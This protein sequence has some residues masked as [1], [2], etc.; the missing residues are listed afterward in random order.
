M[1]ECTF[2]L[3]GFSV[4]ISE[5]GYRIAAEKEKSSNFRFIN[6]I[7]GKSMGLHLSNF[8]FIDFKTT[9]IE[10]SKKFL[11]KLELCPIILLFC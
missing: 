4:G 11:I 2:K 3:W 1:Y 5:V 10:S 6:L 7:S 8:K 9:S